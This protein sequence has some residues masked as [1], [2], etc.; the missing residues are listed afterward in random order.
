[1]AGKRTR[2]PGE[3]EDEIMRVL[4]SH[5]DELSAKEIQRLATGHPPAYTTVMTAL[6]RLEQKSLVVRVT[7]SERKVRF[8]AAHSEDEH[9]SRAMV[10]ALD[11][12]SDRESALLQFA[13]NLDARDA[14]LLR[15][16]IA[17]PGPRG[18]G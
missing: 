9:A 8:R 14:E 13:G 1:M 17:K 2:G 3:L 12:A 10:S 18:S 4:R 7:I 16:A 5:S 6:D 11:D 15:K